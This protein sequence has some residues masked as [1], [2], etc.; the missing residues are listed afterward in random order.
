MQTKA[1]LGD[2]VYVDFDG[3]GIILTSD[4]IQ[5]DRIYLEPQVCDALADY[6]KRIKES[7]K[8]TEGEET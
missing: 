3:Y 8:K 6:V 1:Y 2:G 7:Q 5:R 4:R